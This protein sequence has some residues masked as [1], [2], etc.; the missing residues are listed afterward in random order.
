MEVKLPPR[1]T[2]YG[3]PAMVRMILSILRGIY[4]MR[5]YLEHFD[6]VLAELSCLE[7]AVVLRNAAR[8]ARE[9]RMRENEQA[10]QAHLASQTTQ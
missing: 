3:N 6:V 2:K 9:Q 1:D 8:T 4:C 7:Q 5:K 10:L